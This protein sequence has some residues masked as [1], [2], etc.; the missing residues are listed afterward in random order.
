[1]SIPRD[2]YVGEP[3]YPSP[4]TTRQPREGLRD[5]DEAR[6][7]SL[8]PDVCL[9]PVGSS[10]VP[11]PYP[12]VDYC[13]H[14]KDY[15]PSVRFTGKKAMVMRSC[16]THV[17]GD[18]PGTKRGVKSGTVENICEPIGHAE[19]V[20][21]E[22]SHVIRHLDRF[23]MNNRNTQGE[24]IF[25]RGTQTYAPPKDDDPVV[26]SLRS[27]GTSAN[28]GRVM[29]DA[30]PEPL[31]MGA[32]Y[33]Q[34]N[35]GTMTNGGGGLIGGT[36]RGATTTA[37]TTTT[38]WPKAGSTVLKRFGRWGRAVSLVLDDLSKTQAERFAEGRA[39]QTIL[40]GVGEHVMTENRLLGGRQPISN[41]LDMFSSS[42]WEGKY[43]LIINDSER[44]PLAN[45]ILSTLAGKPMDVRTMSDAEVQSVLSPFQGLSDDQIEQ[46]L[47]EMNEARKKEE[48][49]KKPKPI[50]PP[51]LDPGSNTRVDD[52]KKKEC[53]I[54]PYDDIYGPC[55]ARG[56]KT[57]HVVPD[58]VYRLG[59]RAGKVTTER[60]PNAP[61]EGQGES[62]CLTSDEHSNKNDSGGVHEHIRK[63]FAGID[64][65]EF[66][67]TAPMEDILLRSQAALLQTK[68]IDKVCAEAAN[69]RAAA[70]VKAKTGLTAPGR[71]KEKPLP[72]G[73]IAEVLRNGRYP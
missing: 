70:Q 35:V 48:E 16:T 56:G 8:S 5:L 2:N 13:G 54:G 23:W 63:E 60:V 3:D 29:S 20:R 73:R 41:P 36:T 34:A 38:N 17:H 57:H 10:V 65:P 1:M 72:T 39:F 45:D 14:D 43:G 22:G 52:K 28:E 24:A 50:P 18:A 15:T 25:V 66:P 62:I 61:T 30:S 55:T 51:P 19:Q 67:G 40:S 33:A 69:A 64:H 53:L 31:I 32:Q 58:M 42:A 12:I 49:E 21:A 68:D 7:V 59:D 26:G 27:N 9:T 47:K 44:I 11:I 46:K 4:W 71:T 37:P 6:V